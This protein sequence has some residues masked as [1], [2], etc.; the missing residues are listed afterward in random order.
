MSE[1]YDWGRETA[2]KLAIDEAEYYVL[3]KLHLGEIKAEGI[4]PECNRI[5]VGY[6]DSAIRDVACDVLSKYL[7]LEEMPYRKVL[8][9]YAIWYEKDKDDPFANLMRLTLKRTIYGREADE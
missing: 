6:Y 5:M 2:P 9:L 8:D 1:L 4:E 7:M 3:A